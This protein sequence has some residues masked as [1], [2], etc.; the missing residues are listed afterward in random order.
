MVDTKAASADKQ[1]DSQQEHSSI[2]HNRSYHSPALTRSFWRRIQ[3]RQ[4]SKL[5]E[6]LQ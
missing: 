5:G 3:H 4:V 2:A 1:D 6:I